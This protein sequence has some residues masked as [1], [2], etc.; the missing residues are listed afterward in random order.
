M[1]TEARTGRGGLVLLT[2]APGAGRTRLA[3][4]LGDWA[5]T[6]GLR[7][8]WSRRRLSPDGPSPA[9]DP[10]AQIVRAAVGDADPAALIAELDGVAAVPAYGLVPDLVPAAEL[11]CGRT[12]ADRLAIFDGTARLLGHLARAQPL[13]VVLDD[14]DTAGIASRRFLDFLLPELA[15]IPMLVVAI[16]AGSQPLLS[17]RRVLAWPGPE[18]PGNELTGGLGPE[19]S[20]G[21][22]EQAGNDALADLAWEDAAVYFGHALDA[23]TDAATHDDDRARLLRA[24]GRAL[25][26]AGDID[27]ARSAYTDA[28]DLA[29][30]NGRPDDLARAALGLSSSLDGFEPAGPDPAALPLLEEALA[31]LGPSGP[32]SGRP[33][34][35]VLHAR[36]GARLSMAL[37][38]GVRNAPGTGAIRTPE[39]L[40]MRPRRQELSIDA[41]AL[42]RRLNDDAALAAALVSRCD[43]F[44]GPAH[45]EQRLNDADEIVD[46]GGR[47]GDLETELIGRRLRVV[48]LLEGG[49]VEAVDAEIA[50]FASIT[51]RLGQPRLSWIVALWQGMRALLQGRFAECER[52]NAEVAAL[53]RRARSD[54]VDAL[55][56]VQFFGLRVA[57]DRLVELEA[58]ARALAARPE[59]RAD[60][61]ATHACLLGLLGRD[62]GACGELARLAEGRFGAVGDHDDRWLAALVVLAELAATLDRRPEAAVLYDLLCPHA[63]CFAVEA[64]GAVCHGSVSRHLGLLAHA[65]GRWDEADTHF[66]HAIDDNTSAGAPLLV[67]H[68]RSQWSAL[69]RA[70]DL[71]TDWEQGLELLVGA[72]AIYRRLGVDRLADEA[73]QILARSH[74]PAAS[75]RGGAGNAFR[76]EGDRWLLSYGGAQASVADSLGMHDLAAFLANPGRS[77]HVLDLAAGVFAGGVGQ[78]GQ[79]AR[80]AP[81]SAGNDLSLP[82]PDLDAQARSEYR[83]RLAELDAID[84]T[85]DP[86]RA[87]LARAERDFIDG[88]LADVTGLNELEPGADPA[89]RARRAVAARIRLSLDRIDDVHPALGR[90]LR[91][92]VR[93]ATFCSYEPEI[94]T[95]WPTSGSTG[96]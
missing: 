13:L 89:E 83:A 62:G 21:E 20:A 6:Q 29:R 5:G 74:E 42:A 56:T 28:A 57:Q 79:R 96:G 34:S 23:P 77:F 95:N 53:G 52:R 39:P 84:A 8:L 73:R 86:V 15:E 32:M 75:E 64:M 17:L 59:A 55:A 44:A 12:S 41:V 18:P 81:G 80:P 10:W 38:S 91:H 93:T 26:L 4:Q 85:A 54:R 9:L 11:H 65:L 94:P 27:G 68:T 67:A 90:H 60:S 3:E 31:A 69:R 72:E 7:A 14:F 87:S 2:G 76:P 58:P 82:H 66:R 51:D 71:Q 25:L 22:A 45:R 24:R 61:G 70:R 16:G 50:A 47:S 37:G 19:V 40:G 36:V 63:R 33:A 1:A 30:R 78:A 35:G 48:A 88:E 46:L 92:A 49:L 43:A